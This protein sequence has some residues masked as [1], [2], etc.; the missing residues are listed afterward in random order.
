MGKGNSHT[1][2]K[3]MRYWVFNDW[4]IQTGP[5]EAPG[6]QFV[7]TIFHLLLGAHPHYPRRL[8]IGEESSHT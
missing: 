6:A 5:F 4:G 1:P 2:Q 8:I 3:T 7:L